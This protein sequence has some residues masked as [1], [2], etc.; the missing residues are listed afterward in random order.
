MSKEILLAVWERD[1][2]HAEKSVLAAIAWNADME[3]NNAWPSVGTVARRCGYSPRQV[4]YI[5]KRLKARGIL[6]VQDRLGRRHGFV[7]AYSIN[8]EGVPFLPDDE[9]VQSLQTSSLSPQDLQTINGVTDP[10]QDESLQ[11]E[12]QSLQNGPVS[13]QNEGVSLH[14]SA[15]EQY[16]NS[17]KEQEEKSSDFL[18]SISP[19]QLQKRMR[20]FTKPHRYEGEQLSEEATR[21]RRQALKAQAASWKKK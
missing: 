16:L 21:E 11:S 12:G 14:T 13:L 8:L 3:G 6:V 20:D 19:S 10:F 7:T 18:D 9:S 1:L 17:S 5:V 15:E 4:H 2:P